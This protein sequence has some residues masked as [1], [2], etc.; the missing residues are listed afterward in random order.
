MAGWPRIA[1]LCSGNDLVAREGT[2]NA[3]LHS[4]V[5]MS[6]LGDVEVLEIQELRRVVEELRRSAASTAPSEA[7]FSAEGGTS[8]A[9]E[10]PTF[11]VSSVG[12]DPA[13]TVVITIAQLLNAETREMNAGPREIGPSFDLESLLNGSTV[14]VTMA[15][16]YKAVPGEA[17]HQIASMPSDA[18]PEKWGR[19]K[20]LVRAD[21]GDMV[22]TG[23]HLGWVEG[24]T[25][26]GPI[27]FSE[28][29]GC[30]AIACPFHWC[31]VVKVTALEKNLAGNMNQ[32]L[33]SGEHKVA[34]EGVRNK[35]KLCP[36]GRPRRQPR[37]KGPKKDIEW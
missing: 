19:G 8:G 16:K 28:A 1:V 33:K 4:G 13:S 37:S 2:P 31:K 25:T 10:F 29:H 27:Y 15:E 20:A 35:T 22:V 30:Y 5:Q 11:A 34:F 24:G 3:M 14:V 12:E 18:D 26:A 9:G 23:S 21:L 17:Q 36:A 7:E 6:R 32:H